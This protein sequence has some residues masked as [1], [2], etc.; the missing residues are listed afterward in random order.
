VAQKANY[1]QQFSLL[2][3]F[4]NAS[5]CSTFLIAVSF[6]TSFWWI[7]VSSPVIWDYITSEDHSRDTRIAVCLLLYIT[8]Q[9]HHKWWMEYVKY[10][11][12][13]SKK[14][15]EWCS[16]TDSS[17]HDW[18]E[19]KKRFFN[20]SR[21]KQK[22]ATSCQTFPTG[23]CFCNC[24]QNLRTFTGHPLKSRQRP[25]IRTNVVWEACERSRS[26]AYHRSNVGLPI[27]LRLPLMQSTVLRI[28]MEILNIKS[29][30][31][32]LYWLRFM[33]HTKTKPNNGLS[34]ATFS[35]ALF[36]LNFKPTNCFNFAIFHAKTS[37]KL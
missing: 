30:P 36:L 8:W 23:M 15:A 13:S 27:G 5:F 11:V 20:R 24:S 32:T 17:Q 26:R 7:A 37:T 28:F 6:R 9:G 34:G 14:C 12:R 22:V 10:K 25:I 35:W 31:T 33:I 19:R 21:P 3:L 29:F 16:V 18:L 4:L 1:C 2:H